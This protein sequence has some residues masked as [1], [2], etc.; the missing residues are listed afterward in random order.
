[1]LRQP[2]EVRGWAQRLSA[3]ADAPEA[4]PT[5][6]R[7]TRARGTSRRSKRGAARRRQ[8]PLQN[9]VEF[10]GREVLDAAQAW[11][12]TANAAMEREWEQDTKPPTKRARFWR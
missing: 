4:Q 7:R 12:P 11:D 3:W 2:D 5:A 9:F 8:D 1:M 6:R 10:L